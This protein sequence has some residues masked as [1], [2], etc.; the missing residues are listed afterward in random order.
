MVQNFD[1]YDNK[2][3]KVVTNQPSPVVISGLNPATKYSGYKIAYTGKDAKTTIDDFTTT[4]QV[5]GKP[6]LAISAGD[7]KLDVTFSDG[8]NIGTAVTKRTIYWKTADGHNGT[9][10]FGTS[11]TGS[12]DGLTN[13]TEYTLQGVCTNAAGD[14]EKSDEVKGTPVAPAQKPAQ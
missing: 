10:D 5:P 8:Q 1:I 11:L 2:D 7:G 12:V 4:N 13:G 6:S 14:S 3:E 9:A